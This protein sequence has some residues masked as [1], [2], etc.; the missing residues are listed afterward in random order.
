[1]SASLNRAANRNRRERDVL[2]HIGVDLLQGDIGAVLIWKYDL[3]LYLEKLHVCCMACSVLIF[4]A[5]H[6]LSCMALLSRLKSITVAFLR[7]RKGILFNALLFNFQCS[8]LPLYLKKKNIYMWW[9]VPSPAP[10]HF[11]WVLPC[12]AW[13]WKLFHVFILGTWLLLSPFPTPKP[14]PPRICRAGKAL[15]VLAKWNVWSWSRKA[16][17][18]ALSLS[19]GV[20]YQCFEQGLLPLCEPK[21]PPDF[22]CSSGGTSGERPKDFFCPCVY[23]TQRDRQGCHRAVPPVLKSDFFWSF[24]CYAHLNLGG[25][26]KN[27]G[28]SFSS[29]ATHPTPLVWPGALSWLQHIIHF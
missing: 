26:K 24:L 27:S 29:F 22:L 6:M 1:M 16:Q 12:L 15:P 3:F 4:K 19:T 14:V 21:F 5:V 11:T 9:Y 18:T 2:F 13:A 28:W 8:S 23:V 25:E 7:V 20:A 10:P 17:G